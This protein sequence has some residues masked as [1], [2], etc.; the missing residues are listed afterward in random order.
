MNDL[1]VVIPM[2]DPAL[3]KSRL[4]PVLDDPSRER[5]ARDLFTN[6]LILLN[7]IKAAGMAFDIAVITA[8]Q[9]IAAIA[10]DFGAAL[11]DETIVCGLN[12]AAGRAA[13][14]AKDGGWDRL[15]ILPADL[16]K[17]DADELTRFLS[18]HLETPSVVI[19]P[20]TDLGTNALLVSPPDSITF[21]YGPLS[22]HQHCR[23]ADEAGIVANILPF[24][25]LRADLDSPAD[26]PSRSGEA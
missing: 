20:S 23:L 22:F 16:A 12:I 17:P 15:C 6:T 19:C 26:L 13:I 4:R 5:L 8:S 21:A 11:I 14:Y 7:E 25:S 24:P 10:Q 2:K 18:Y 3:A 9:N 1:L